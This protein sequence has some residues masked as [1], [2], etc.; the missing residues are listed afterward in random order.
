[1]T[2]KTKI[3]W[4]ALVVAVATSLLIYVP[5]TLAGS[6]NNNSNEVLNPSMSTMMNEEMP[7]FQLNGEIVSQLLRRFIA[8]STLV[9]IHGNVVALVKR[10]LVLN[11]ADGQVRVL[12]PATWIVGEKVLEKEDL[13][14]TDYLTIGQNISVKTLKGTIVTRESYNIYVLFGYEII[15]TSGVHAYAVLPFNIGTP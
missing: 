8:N 6:R 4:I 3:L 5:L 15:N 10:I 1:M 9:E 11:T 7:R 13:F 14:K 2:S 12:L